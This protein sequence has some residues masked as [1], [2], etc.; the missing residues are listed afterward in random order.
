MCYSLHCIEGGKLIL[1]TGR[2]IAQFMKNA[3]WLMTSSLCGL[4][5]ND[6]CQIWDYRD[7]HFP[8]GM[9]SL[10]MSIP[11]SKGEFDQYLCEFG[12]LHLYL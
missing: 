8:L 6:N 4:I 12:G 9:F 3:T 7:S 1:L 5:M 2:L 11:L 10:K